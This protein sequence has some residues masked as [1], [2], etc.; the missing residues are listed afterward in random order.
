MSYSSANQRIEQN[1][2]GFWLIGVFLYSLIRLSICELQQK[3]KLEMVS[4]LGLLS[5]F[6]RQRKPHQEEKG[7]HCLGWRWSKH[8]PSLIPAGIMPAVKGH[9]CQDASYWHWIQAG[10]LAGID[11]RSLHEFFNLWTSGFSDVK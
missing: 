9:S 3:L 10:I 7:S 1:P 4:D 11:P 5:R 6:D 2:Q 8:P